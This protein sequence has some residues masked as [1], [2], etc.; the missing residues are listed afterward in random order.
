LINK[1]TLANGITVVNQEIKEAKTCAI[2]IGLPFG[3]RD[4]D[5]D[6]N[7]YTHFLE[8]ILFKGTGSYST[9]DIASQIESAG[10]QINGYT[11]REE[12]FLQI[13]MPSVRLKEGLDILLSMFFDPLFEE[14]EIQREKEV[15]I[16]ELESIKDDPEELLQDF[17][18][19]KNFPDN[20][21]AYPIGGSVENI[22]GLDSA[23]ISAFYQEIFST[24]DLV[25]VMVG[26]SNGV[27]I[28]EILSRYPRRKRGIRIFNPV[29]KYNYSRFHKRLGFNQK[30]I[31][32]TKPLLQA[33]TLP[34]SLKAQIFSY[35]FGES[36]SSRLFQRI[37]EKLGLCYNVGSFHGD[38]REFQLF[39]IYANTSK[40]QLKRTKE[41]LY[42]EIQLL[43]QGVT[44]DEWKKAKSHFIGSL[45][46][47]EGD[48]DFQAKRLFSNSIS[49]WPLLTTEDM[50]NMIQ[51]ISIDAL[52]LYMRQINDNMWTEVIG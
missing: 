38:F 3:S 22:K 43:E 39:Q 31:L 4:E 28:E 36:M 41:A 30:Q 20:P 29:Q 12:V 14:N 37:R 27:N 52:N 21:I 1:L 23:K 51:S 7:G 35:V 48:Y 40:K 16:T 32:L 33:P 11:D 46:L 45:L 47:S 5:K 25:F 15:V 49:N 26:N 50:I 17:N 18:F 10:G 6:T 8:H 44:D 24:E 19:K 9:F 13:W 34:T 42:K 2:G